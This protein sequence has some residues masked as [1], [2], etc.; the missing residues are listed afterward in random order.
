MPAQ[1]P[2]NIGWNDGASFE[3]FVAGPN[4][5]ALGAVHQLL[6]EPGAPA[7]YL[8]GVDGVGKSHLLQAACRAC[9]QDRQPGFY[10]PLS[11]AEHW[12]PGMLEGLESMRLVAL[13]D[14]DAIAGDRPREEAVF[15][16]F[17]RLRDSGTSL[18]MAAS[19]RPMD[20]GWVLPDLGSR[21][22]WGLVE[23]LQ[24]LDDESLLQALRRR[25]EMRGLELPDE[26][27]RYLLSRFPRRASTLFHLLDRLDRAALAAQRRLT[28][29]FVKTVID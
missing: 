14:V 11:P 22:A 16:L 10:L 12:H 27:G 26:T 8:Y 1:L 15:H 28:V 25:A 7:V 18:L 23:R 5:R 19:A 9:G 21:L 6:E 4:A 3:Q 13:D 29:P 2:L 17:N 24:P 20:V